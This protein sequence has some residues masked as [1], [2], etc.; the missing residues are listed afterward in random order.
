MIKMNGLM[1]LVTFFCIFPAKASIDE[2]GAVMITLVMM[3][4]W[5]SPFRL[6]LVCITA[7]LCAATDE[8]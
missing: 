2:N 7:I 5:T 6:Y 4:D 8:L 1:R 3:V